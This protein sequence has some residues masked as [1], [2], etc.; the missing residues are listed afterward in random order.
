MFTIESE[1]FRVV[2]ERDNVMLAGQKLMR[3]ISVLMGS[4]YEALVQLSPE[5]TRVGQVEDQK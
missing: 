4:S 2:S 1:S 5:K 3:C